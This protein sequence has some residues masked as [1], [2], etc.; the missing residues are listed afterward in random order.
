MKKFFVGVL[1]VVMSAAFA[2]TVSAA[3][4]SDII[5]KLQADGATAT[6]IALAEDYLKSNG[7]QFTSAQLDSIST[8]IDQGYSLM[9]KYGV[10]D[11]TKL[12]ASAKTELKNI[13]ISTA[14]NAGVAV[15]FG[16]NA[17]G[18][19]TMTLS[20]DGKSY[21]FSA[22]DLKTK[23]TGAGSALPFAGV[24]AG[25]CLV[26]GSAAYLARNRKKVAVA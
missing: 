10:N 5:S 25:L 24:A 3:T 21:T 18:V 4:P 7:S 9:K 22:N 23:T 1:A 19:G 14:S 13:V 26:L 15:S 12:P 16:K 17:S 20:N 11:P 2:V 8:G 6:Q